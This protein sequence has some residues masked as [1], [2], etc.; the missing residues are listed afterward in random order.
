M[1]S[2]FEKLKEIN[3]TSKVEK[4]G[5]FNYLS[6]AFAVDE[7]LKACPE[8]TWTVHEWNDLPF[9][10]TPENGYFVAVTIKV[11]EIRRTQYHPILDNKNKTIFKP[12]SFDINT[13]IQRCLAKAIA[14]HGLGLCLFSGEDLPPDNTP[15]PPKTY[16]EEL[17]EIVNSKKD[18]L[19]SLLE[20]KDVPTELDKIAKEFNV[21]SLKD[22]EGF[23]Q[24]K[25]ILRLRDKL[26]EIKGDK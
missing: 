11:D 20:A 19:V 24:A 17:N 9:T 22:V 23:D 16:E 21:T 4:K 18:G 6:W 25:V 13:A 3:V 5:Q 12:H 1:S 14:L 26:K 10:G 7:L 2:T 8:A 15:P